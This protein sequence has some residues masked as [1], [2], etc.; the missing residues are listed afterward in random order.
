VLEVGKE[1]RSKRTGS[2]AKVVERGEGRM[3]Y[4]RAYKAH[5]GH[6]DP[7][8]H[9]DLTQTW[10]VIDGEGSIEVDGEVRRF[11]AGDEVA[12]EPGTP[13]RDPFTG[14]GDLTVRAT[15]APCPPFIEAFGEAI[16][17][18]AGNGTLNDQDELPLLQILL[19]AK[20]YD[21]RSYRAGIPVWLQKATLPLVAGVARL[22]GYRASYTD[23]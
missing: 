9:Q 15:F 23:V 10:R 21:G 18:H 14:E 22:R 2:I 12:I 13:H 20:E 6:A 17:H 5:S 11:A 1:Y 19:L 16:A 7:H 3:V 4:E 8:L